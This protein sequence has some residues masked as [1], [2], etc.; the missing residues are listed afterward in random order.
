[1]EKSNKLSILI[2][3]A[4]IAWAGGA[5]IGISAEHMSRSSGGNFTQDSQHHIHKQSPHAGPLQLNDLLAYLKELENSA[6]EQTKHAAKETL[7]FAGTLSGTPVQKLSKIIDKFNEQIG[8]QKASEAAMHEGQ[9]H[10]L[11]EE[12]KKLLEVA[13]SVTQKSI[14][15]KT[16]SREDSKQAFTRLTKHLEEKG[17]ADF[18]EKEQIPQAGQNAE[19]ERAEQA[20]EVLQSKLSMNTIGTA[21]IIFNTTQYNLYRKEAGL[22]EINHQQDTIEVSQE[23]IKHLLKLLLEK[24][25]QAI[26]ISAEQGEHETHGE[27]NIKKKIPLVQKIKIF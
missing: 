21:K 8:I 7:H 11:P 17:L 4:F 27:R 2:S 12:E 26:L 1:M 10:G 16:P 18:F 3:T 15:S 25:Y 22:G 6:H 23:D 13:R 14:K 19:V 24:L 9:A 5:G 20:V